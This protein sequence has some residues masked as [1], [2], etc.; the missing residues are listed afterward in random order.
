M[1]FTGKKVIITGANGLVGLPAVKKCLDEGAKVF[2]VDLKFSDNILF[3][4]QQKIL[5]M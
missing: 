3:L 2:A 1:E 4:Q 5:N